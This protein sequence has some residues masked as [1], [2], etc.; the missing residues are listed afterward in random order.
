MVDAI[1]FNMALNNGKLKRVASELS[2]PALT[3]SSSFMDVDIS[4]D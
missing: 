1:V 4:Y 3:V 2:F